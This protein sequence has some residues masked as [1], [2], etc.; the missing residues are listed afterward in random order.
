MEYNEKGKIEKNSK[1]KANN[2]NQELLKRN[3]EKNNFKY[4]YNINEINSN[5]IYLK[6]EKFI[7]ISTEIFF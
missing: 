4:N 1:Q 6:K 3:K 2:N 5:T 7:D